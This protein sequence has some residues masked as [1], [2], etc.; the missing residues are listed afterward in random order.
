MKNMDVSK[1]K[2]LMGQA[3]EMQKMLEEQ[4]KRILDE[5]IKKRGLISRKEVEE[6][7]KR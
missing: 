5:E 1:M 3:G 4:I 7:L 6:I 2:E